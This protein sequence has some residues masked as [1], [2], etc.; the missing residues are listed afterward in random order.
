MEKLYNVVY[1]C[2][3]HHE[4]TQSDVV[5]KVSSIFKISPE[6]AERFVT[7]QKPRIIKQKLPL[8]VA[9]IYKD[10]LTKIGLTIDLKE[11]KYKNDSQLIPENTITSHEKKVA[12]RPVK[13]NSQPSKVQAEKGQILSPYAPPKS[14]LSKQKDNVTKKSV[15]D[16]LKNLSTWKLLFLSAIT[17][18]IYSA[19]YIKRQSEVINEY[20]DEELRISGGF[21]Y[22]ILIL[23]YFSVLLIIPH[24]LMDQSNPINIVSN[25][26]DRIWNFMILIWAFM[27]RS[28]LN[29]LLNSDKATGSWFHGF[30]TFLFQQLYFNYKINQL[31]EIKT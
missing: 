29:T 8:K 6:K 9:K 30:W 19:H 23:S 1:D 22:T 31:N 12:V 20:V 2:K 21:I 18:G 11:I 17:L 13:L 4:A 16:D 27:A 7:S 28:R 15:L 14:N 26:S 10:K 5:S 24:V 25:L 3:I